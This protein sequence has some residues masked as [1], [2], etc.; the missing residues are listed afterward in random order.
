MARF[1][2]KLVTFFALFLSTSAYAVGS[3]SSF[4]VSGVV[5]VVLQA[6]VVRST[7]L[8][9]TVR[10]VSNNREGYTITM[11]TDVSSARYNGTHVNVID[12]QAVLTQVI[13][14]D[15]SVDALKKLVFSTKPTYVR[16]AIEVM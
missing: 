5:P 4:A 11:Q 15:K 16:I 14:Q 1:Q 9:Y 13:S 10:E 3:S 7:D 2:I 8:A 12:G 6:N